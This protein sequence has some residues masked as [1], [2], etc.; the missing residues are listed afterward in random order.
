MT[1]K[2]IRTLKAAI[3]SASGLHRQELKIRLQV[4]LRDMAR[5][6][7]AAKLQAAAPFSL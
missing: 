4:A 3:A 1:A 5:R 7:Y 2:Q 6:D